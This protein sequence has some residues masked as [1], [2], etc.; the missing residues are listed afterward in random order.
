MA[1]PTASPG[2]TASAAYLPR[3]RI[4]RRTMTDAVGW[5]RGRVRP[6]QGTR[7]FAHWD[8]DSLTLAVEAGRGIDSDAPAPARLL[9]ASTSLPF[10]DRSNAGIVREALGL[11]A[12]TRLLESGGSRRAATSALIE[13]LESGVS[14]LLCASDCVDAQP[15]S[16]GETELGHGAAAVL[17]G[18]GP[19]LA[20][21][22][23]WSTRSSDFVDRYRQADRRFD[24]RLEARWTRDAGIRRPLKALIGEVLESAGI[25]AGDVSY[26]LAG[27]PASVTRVVAKD[28]G[29]EDADLLADVEAEVGLCGAAQ[30]LLLLDRALTRAGAGQLILLIGAGQGFDVILLRATGAARRESRPARVRVE[31]NYT[32]YLGLRRLME[33]DGGLRAE[34]DNRSAQ[35]AAARRHEELH[36]FLGGRCSACGKLQFPRS[37]LCLHCRAAGTQELEPMADL[38]G[39]VNSFTEDW[40]AWTPRPPLIFGN[41]HF[42]DGA[43]VMLEFTDFEAGELAAGDAVRMAFRIKDFDDRRGFRRYFWKPAPAETDH[44]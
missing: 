30:P 9:L 19:G 18:E 13:S 36:G 15:G 11:P 3:W 31:P 26:C 4:E 22:L 41:V 38:P 20:E 17:V 34:R 8:E 37:E 40:L 25:Q 28:A 24:Y 27:L 7:S 6:G 1:G 32:R 16:E 21:A 10:A 23:A 44:G 33:I 39:E 42:P 43:N 29:L 2:I 5:A 14:T 12:S 35:S